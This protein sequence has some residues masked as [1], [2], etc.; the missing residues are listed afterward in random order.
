MTDPLRVACSIELAATEEFEPQERLSHRGENLRKLTGSAARLVADGDP[1]DRLTT[2]G[3][4]AAID[5]SALQQA[6]HEVSPIAM[7]GGGISMPP[8]YISSVILHTKKKKLGGHENDF[9]AHG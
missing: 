5:S 3:F 6:V 8:M 7:G 9:T 4:A 1:A 2:V